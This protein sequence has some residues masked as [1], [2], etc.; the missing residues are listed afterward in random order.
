MTYF[1]PSSTES[2][3]LNKHTVFKIMLLKLSLTF[4]IYKGTPGKYFDINLV[5]RYSDNFQRT[6]RT[7]MNTVAKIF[8]W[9]HQNTIS[10][11]SFHNNKKKHIPNKMRHHS[12]LQ[13]HIQNVGKSWEF[14]Q[15][16]S[17]NYLLL[18]LILSKDVP[19]Q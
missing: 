11:C 14:W 2:A 9:I 6:Y 4:H 12:W 5:T 15:L 17:L 1:L 18:Y 13:H 10:P 8:Q 16:K 19:P 7:L 3:Y